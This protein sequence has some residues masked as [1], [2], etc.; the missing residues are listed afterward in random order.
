MSAPGVATVSNFR[1]ALEALEPV[2][3]WRIGR[4]Y[5]PTCRKLAALVADITV[6]H[7]RCQRRNKA[8]VTCGAICVPAQGLDNV[9]GD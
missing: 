3:Y 4:V 5:C 2:T 8:G 7:I 9:D 1:A 6:E